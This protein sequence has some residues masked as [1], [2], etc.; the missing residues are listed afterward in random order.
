MLQYVVR[1]LLLAIPTLFAISVLSFVIIQLPPGD[2][3]TNYAAQLAQMGEGTA[4]EQLEA[5][6]QAYGLGEPIYV[7]YWK[8]ISGIVLRGDFGLS[9]E[10]KLPVAQLIW[11]RLGWT[12]FLTATTILVGWLIAI[13]IGVYSATH[14]YSKLD[15]LINA[16]GFFGLGIPNFTMALAVMW[17]AY[18]FLGWDLA[19]LFSDEFKNAPWSL[20]KLVDM[21]GHLWLPI[22]TLAW[23]EVASLQRTMRA[24]LLDELSKPYVTAARAGGLSETRLVWEYPVRVALNPFVSAIGFSLPELI[25]SAT[26]ISIVLAL[27]MTGPLL[28]TALQAQDMYLAGAFILLI[29]TLTIVGMLISDILLAWLDPRIRY[30]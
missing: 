14:Q 6:R 16:W 4:A 2:F 10:W 17:F 15:H 9:M 1:R 11:D 21:L 5:L 27:P 23:D 13:P 22:L 19:G 20:G 29:G 18:A 8:W 12:L 30:G 7:Q 26:L 25:S 24:N 3:L 28:L